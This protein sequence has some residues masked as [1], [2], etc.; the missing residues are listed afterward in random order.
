MHEGHFWSFNALVSKLNCSLLTIVNPGLGDTATKYREYVYIR[1]FTIYVQG[2][3]G[4]II[5]CTCLKIGMQFENSYI[6][7]GT[8]IWDF[9]GCATMTYY[10]GLSCL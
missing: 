8:K 7:K 3:F 10:I 6:E 1:T 5:W 2:H 4:V 9:C